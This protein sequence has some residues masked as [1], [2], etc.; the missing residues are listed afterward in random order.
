MKIARCA[1]ALLVAAFLVSCK[2]GGSYAVTLDQD[3]G[4]LANPGPVEFLPVTY[5]TAEIGDRLLWDYTR[6]EDVSEAWPEDRGDWEEDMREE[7]RE[8][9]DGERAGGERTRVHLN[10]TQVEPGWY[11]SPSVHQPGYVYGEV[12]ILG[13]GDE[14]LYKFEVVGFSKKIGW[15][16]ARSYEQVGGQIAKF[17]NDRRD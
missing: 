9:F 2:A 14:P 15:R 8:E 4:P 12:E 17:Y 11:V 6:V 3:S 16:V 5:R 1:T 10:V 7:F 13:S